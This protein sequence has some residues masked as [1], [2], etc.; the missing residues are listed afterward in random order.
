[1]ASSRLHSKERETTHRKL[2][3]KE[4]W[5]KGTALASMLKRAKHPSY[6]STCTMELATLVRQV[7]QQRHVRLRTLIPSCLAV[8]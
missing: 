6:G 3:S 2:F 7:A 4:S 8:L 5:R 1:M